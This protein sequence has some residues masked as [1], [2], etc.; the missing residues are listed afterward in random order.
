MTTLMKYKSYFELESASGIDDPAKDALVDDVVKHF[1][2]S[3]KCREADF[4]S[5][6]LFAIKEL[7]NETQQ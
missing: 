1:A 3:P 4:I 2:R 5:E 6:F 7:R